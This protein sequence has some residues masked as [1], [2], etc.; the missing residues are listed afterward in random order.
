MV[1]GHGADGVKSPEVIFIRVVGT[2]PGDNVKGR[3]ILRGGE[4]VAAEFG[5]H[6]PGGAD[7]FVKVCD[8]D[9]KVAFVRKTV[10]ADGAEVGQ[11]EVALVEF[12]CVAAHGAVGKGNAVTDAAR[13]DG[14]LV[15]PDEEF[16]QLGLDVEDAV[17][18]DDEQVAVGGVEGFM[19]VHVFTGGEDVIADALFHGGIAGAGDKAER[20][21]PVHRLVQ[22]EGIPS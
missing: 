8:G 9:L 5:E 16:A 10:A 21:H 2:V 19:R 3:V 11:V 17:L 7:V 4:E 14:N 12:Q 18:G 20:M 1:V 22:V 15:G 6:V 13:D